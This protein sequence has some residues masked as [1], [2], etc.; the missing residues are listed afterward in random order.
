MSWMEQRAYIS[1][2]RLRGTHLLMA[3]KPY[4]VLL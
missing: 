3:K 4:L 2:S 1:A